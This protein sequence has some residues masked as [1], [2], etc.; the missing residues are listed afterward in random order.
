MLAEASGPTRAAQAVE[1]LLANPLLGGAATLSQATALA[2]YVMGG[3][4]LGTAEVNR[5]MDQVHR[6]CDT[7]PISMG[8]A[9]VPELGDRLLV[10]LLVPEREAGA[11]SPENDD[12]PAGEPARRGQAEELSAQ[13]VN[14]TETSRRQSRFVPPPPAVP[15]ERMAQLF[16]DHARSTG[17]TRKPSAKLRQGNLPLD[18]VSKG[19]FDKSEPTIHKGE[20]LDVPTYIRRGVALN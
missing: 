14:R 19:R 17:R 11:D 15:P 9:I 20:D 16:K 8:A 3:P 12:D 13:L 2:V 7:A 6:Q 1:R 4:A 5:I 18:I 10:G